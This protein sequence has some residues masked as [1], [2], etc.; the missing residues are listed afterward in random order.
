MSEMPRVGGG[1]QNVLDN[2]GDAMQ[3]ASVEVGNSLNARLL[4]ILEGIGA[5]VA[6][7]AENGKFAELGES[8]A[9]LAT[10]SSAAAGG[11]TGLVDK[12]NLIAVGLK[13]FGDFTGSIWDQLRQIPGSTPNLIDWLW[14]GDINREIG[15]Q[16]ASIDAQEKD[17]RV[18]A[19]KERMAAREEA[20]K[21][22][23]AEETVSPTV[24]P[25]V[26]VLKKIE[27]NTRA[28]PDITRTIFGG[29]ELGRMGVTA[30]EI[31]AQR[32]SR[33]VAGGIQ[34]QAQLIAMQ[35]PRLTAR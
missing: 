8:L 9:N 14:G 10:S 28:L 23:G 31:R 24:S 21:K 13:N 7:L 22:K 35:T 29:G 19:Y 18:I 33:K 27:E 17:P 12:L 30:H 5:E 16:Q 15:K 11:V 20:N 3:R 25:A 6:E 2:V 1:F 4:P 26:Q 32:L 34:K